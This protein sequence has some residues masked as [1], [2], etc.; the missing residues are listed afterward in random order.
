MT[1]RT[2]LGGKRERAEGMRNLFDGPQAGDCH[3]K[4]PH[5]AGKTDHNPPLAQE[6]EVGQNQQE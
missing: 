2:R 1:P 3:L 4:K 6:F 5:A